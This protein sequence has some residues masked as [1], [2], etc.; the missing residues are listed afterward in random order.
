MAQ[1]KPEPRP[2]VGVA[3]DG[4]LAESAEILPEEWEKRS[5]DLRMRE[6]SLIHI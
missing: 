2:P 4:D 1:E 3:F 6:L 5:L